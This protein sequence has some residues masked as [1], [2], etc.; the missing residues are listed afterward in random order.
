M[1]S[2][3]LYGCSGLTSA[4]SIGGGYDYEFGW[5]D[6]IPDN[7]FCG[8]SRLTSVT[9]PESVT[10]IGDAVFHHC[11]GLTNVA[12][13][14]SVTSIGFYA[15]E[16]CWRLTNVTIPESVTSIGSYAFYGCS[17]LINVFYGG[18]EED[19]AKISVGSDNFAL[20]NATIHYNSNKSAGNISTFTLSR[21][22]TGAVNDTINIS[23]E[24]TLSDD[25][26]ASSDTLQKEIDNIQ[27]TTSDKEIAEV[28]KCNGLNAMDNRSASLMV[29]VT[30]YKEGTVTIT[31]TTSNGLAK[32]C[33]VTVTEK[34]SGDEESDITLRHI[35]G[36]LR[37]EEH[38]S[39]LQS[40]Y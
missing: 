36:E 34:G 11:I 32:S 5:K 28:T 24:I 22:A 15:F 27:W 37:S 29:Y 23:G 7:A 2:S 25:I 6:K 13:P 40:P 31:G 33:K 14:E 30:A 1:C 21:T 9:M 19:W 4:G 16:D 26:E 17:G 12:I 35:T 8:C 18:N 10:S 39:E 3:D 20:T 38:T